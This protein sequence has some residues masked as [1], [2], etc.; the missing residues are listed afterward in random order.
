MLYQLQHRLGAFKFEKIFTE[1]SDLLFGNIGGSLGETSAIAIL[2]G[3][4]F[5]LLMKNADWRIPL[6]FT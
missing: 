6:S 5:L 3:G 1:Y 2:I 4:I